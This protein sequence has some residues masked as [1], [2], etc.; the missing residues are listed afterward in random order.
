MGL[1]QNR[2]NMPSGQRYRGDRVSGANY[3]GMGSGSSSATPNPD[4]NNYKIEKA[5][6]VGKFLIIKLRYPN[7]TNYEGNKILVYQNTTLIDLINQKL[8]DPH[9]SDTKGFKSPIA[10][11][12]PTEGGWA[13]AR[14]FCEAMK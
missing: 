8:I 7:C 2:S 14:K 5:E 13:M 3:S 9:F 10:R 6:E 12:I 11:F 4:P 1:K